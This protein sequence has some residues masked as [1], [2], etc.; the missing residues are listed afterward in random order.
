MWDEGRRI[1]LD[2]VDKDLDWMERRTKQHL[3]IGKGAP[4]IK[5][6]A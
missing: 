5:L 3:K 6:D 1:K 4:I 2:L